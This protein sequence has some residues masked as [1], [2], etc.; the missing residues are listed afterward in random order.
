[1]PGVSDHGEDRKPGRLLLPG[2]EVVWPHAYM[3]HDDKGSLRSVD[4]S[5]PG[6]LP[7]VRVYNTPGYAWGLFV[8]GGLRPGTGS[9]RRRGWTI[10]APW[11]TCTG[12][13]WNH[14]AGWC[15]D[16]MARVSVAM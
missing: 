13:G 11:R 6:A 5:N 7:E 16:R 12:C 3:A 14:R 8:A 9:T 4:V 2:F 10:A 15:Q 1:M